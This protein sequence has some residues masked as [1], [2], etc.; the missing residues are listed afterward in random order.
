[1]L[2]NTEESADKQRIYVILRCY[3]TNARSFLLDV[4]IYTLPSLVRAQ[5]QDL[6]C[7]LTKIVPLYNRRYSFP[8]NKN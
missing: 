8:A 2:Y 4:S 1:V 3:E 7:T 6:R 5:E